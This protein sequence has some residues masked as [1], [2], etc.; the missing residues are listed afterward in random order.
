MAAIGTTLSIA[1]SAAQALPG[2]NTNQAKT[3]ANRFF[4]ND[5][6]KTFVQNRTL[7]FA[8]LTVVTLSSTVLAIYFVY[9]KNVTLN[10]TDKENEFTIQIS[11]NRVS[12]SPSGFTFQIPSSTKQHAN[13][14]FLLPEDLTL[15]FSV[16]KTNKSIGDYV[17]EF[18]DNACS[19]KTEKPISV[20]GRLRTSYAGEFVPQLFSVNGVQVLERR[21]KKVLEG[22]FERSYYIVGAGR[23]YLLKFSHES[24][25]S[26]LETLQNVLKSI[27]F[28]N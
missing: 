11:G 7:I 23:L 13:Q 1:G 22:V 28:H 10:K 6:K 5:I 26:K 20:N 3:I 12:V 18:K 2:A 8:T 21:P 16:S 24:D 15:Q 14:K 4:N 9:Q 25:P 17:E 27:V 19:G